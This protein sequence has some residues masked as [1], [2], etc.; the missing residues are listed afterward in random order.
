[1]NGYVTT[2]YDGKWWIAYVL[3]KNEELDEVKLTFLHP[4]GPSNSFFYPKELDVLWLPLTQVLCKVYPVTPTGRLY[5]LSES[6]TSK[7]NE[8]FINY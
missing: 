6:D 2:V 5:I 8:A 7:I 3:E 4:A 1:M